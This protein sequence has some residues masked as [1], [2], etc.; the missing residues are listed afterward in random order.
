MVRTNKSGAFCS[1][2][3]VVGADT[4]C[5]A[6]MLTLAQKKKGELEGVSMMKVKWVITE[7]HI[8]HCLVLAVAEELSFPILVVS[9]QSDIINLS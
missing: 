9:F 5:E 3:G 8:G 6:K 2:L 4:G 7:H 1:R